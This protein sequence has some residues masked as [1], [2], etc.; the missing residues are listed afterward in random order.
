M[1]RAQRTLPPYALVGLAGLLVS[2]A[3]M[4]AKIE[5]FWSWHTPIAWTGYILLVDGLVRRRRGESW[6]TTAPV[7][8]A[9]LAAA[10]FPL[11]LVFEFYNLYI[12]NWHYINLPSSAFWRNLGYVW[13]FATIWPALFETADLISSFRQPAG[14][15]EPVP[16]RQAHA[17]SP[18]GWLS[19]LAGLA[20]LLWPLAWPSP[21]L[22][23]PVWLGFILLLDPLNA[24]LGGESL[25]GDYRRGSVTRGVNLAA[26]GLVCGIVWE[27]WNYWC[28]SKWIYTVPV[29]AHLKV[30]EMPLPGYGGFPVFALECFTMYVTIRLLVWRGRRRPIA[31]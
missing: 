14:A 11:W 1:N 9:F 20:M 3:G 16:V 15:R 24:R 19:M 22:A 12:R 18:L 6:L 2:E 25:T 26:A 28:R 4:L 23:A 17:V 13:S 27:F 7:E 5:P 10:S 30:F 8:F 29:L 31:L 21:Y